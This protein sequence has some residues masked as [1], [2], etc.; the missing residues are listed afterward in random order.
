MVISIMVL[1]LGLVAMGKLPISQYPEIT[2]PE[3]LVEG[4]YTGASSV[5]AVPPEAIGGRKHCL[6]IKASDGVLHEFACRTEV[7]KADWIEALTSWFL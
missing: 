5:E 4:T 1:L 3:V 2:P 6:R 7:D